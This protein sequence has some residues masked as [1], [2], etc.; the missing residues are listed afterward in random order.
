MGIVTCTEIIQARLGKSGTAPS[1]Q[2]VKLEVLSEMLKPVMGCFVAGTLV[3]TKDGLKPIDQIKVGDWVL[4]RPENPEEGTETAC[5]RVTQTFRFENKPVVKFDW[6]QRPI[7]DPTGEKYNDRSVKYNAVFVTPNHPVWVEGHGWVAVERLHEPGK[8]QS[9]LRGDEWGHPSLRLMDG[10]AC[11][12]GDVNECF[13]T[14]QSQV[15][16]TDY[17]S[18]FLLYGHLWDF[19]VSPPKK[20]STSLVAYEDDWSDSEA[21][22]PV[23]FATMVYNIEVEDWHTYFVGSTGLWVHNTDC[24]RFEKSCLPMQMDSNWAT[25]PP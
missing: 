21:D 5:K 17:M 1:G 6:F 10:S 22:E 7:D 9:F 2:V 12:I 16:Y 4:S 24:N 18:E 14:D 20:I 25:K 11:H 13:L 15:V 19:A 3:H 23:V 8:R